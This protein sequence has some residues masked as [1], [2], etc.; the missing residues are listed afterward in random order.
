MVKVW[1]GAKTVSSAM[2]WETHWAR[3]TVPACGVPLDRVTAALGDGLAV[4]LGVEVGRFVA[5]ELG[6]GVA[7]GVKASSRVTC[8]N[9]VPAT[10][11]R[12]GFRSRVGVLVGTAGLQAANPSRLNNTPIKLRVL[13]MCAIGLFLCGC[14][15]N[16][17]Q[18]WIF[19]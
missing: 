7:E 5:V 8:A 10:C 16:R 2:D 17:C 9:T 1:P 15:Q 18:P 3:F 19:S 14:W 11:V 13:F 4:R 6:R 12:R